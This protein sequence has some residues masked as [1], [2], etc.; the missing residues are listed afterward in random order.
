MSQIDQYLQK[1][2]QNIHAPSTERERIESDLRAHLEEALASGEPED[3]VLRRMGAPEEVAKG[4]MAQVSLHYAGFWRRLAAF[5]IDLAVV[6]LMAGVLA[7]VG[8]AS[9]SKVP[10]NP[11]GL[12]WA[13]GALLVA[14]AISAG[15]ATIGTILL[16]FPIQEGRFGQTLGKRLLRLWVLKEDGL[17]IGYKEA[18][19]RRL[20]YY[21]DILPVDALFIPFTA[22]RQRA[23]DVVA[24]TVVVRESDDKGV[25]AVFALALVIALPLALMFACFRP[26]NRFVSLC[27]PNP[28]GHV[29]YSLISFTGIERA[30]VP[31]G[32]GRTLTLEHQASLDSG[33]LSIRVEDARGQV[34]WQ[35]ALPVDG[36]SGRQRAEIRVDQGER[37]AI[38]LEG[39][40]AGAK[41]DLSWSRR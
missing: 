6:I 20:S 21:F 17:P 10:R 5:G 2:M 11:V 35:I 22:N 8:V 16:Y 12:D 28:A 1:V 33:G 27:A 7:L 9:V 31:A 18:F 36:A 38:V 19:L 14:L 29:A 34:V 3:A 41:L 37:Y 24:H 4:F 13:V 32:S 25:R 39:R 23:F 26:Q 30:E 15:L 40:E